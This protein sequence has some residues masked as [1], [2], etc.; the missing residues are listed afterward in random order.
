[1]KHTIFRL[2]FS[3]ALLIFLGVPSVRAF[4]SDVLLAGVMTERVVVK[5]EPEQSYAVYLPANYT[6]QR[7]WPTIICFDPGA[8][9]KFAVEHL[10]SAAEKF[11]YVVACSNNSRNALDGE[12]V[13]KIVSALW[14]DTHERIAIND[15]RTYLAGFSG[16]A[17]LAVGLAM[18]CNGCVA[19]VIASGA[20]LPG[21]NQPSAQL[22]FFFFGV[23]GYDDFNFGEMRELE[24]KFDELAT[25]HR[26]YRFAGGHEW[27]PQSAIEKA[28]A[29]FSLEAMKRQVL[30]KDETFIDERF[31]AELNE[32][33]KLRAEQ[34][35]IDSLSAYSYIAQSFGSLRDT[36]LVARKAEELRNSSE[37]KKQLQ[38]ESDLIRRQAQETSDI[39]ALWMKPPQPDE[40][41]TSRAEARNKISEWRKKK[42]AEIDS[43]DRRLARRVL[44]SLRIG[45][46]EDAA[47][48]MR[49]KNYLTA[50]ADLELVR[51]VEPQ[52]SNPAY[53]LARAQ[54]LNKDKK[55]ALQTLTEAVEL[56]FKDFERLKTDPAFAALAADTRFQ[57]LLSDNR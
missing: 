10:K 50:I 44:T 15:Q 18:R 38:L 49:T 8:R 21:I 2:V 16:G 12:T 14:R 25:P 41:L 24:K 54:A 48:A 23:V 46:F 57:K 20:G 6:S 47:G 11:G 35:L 34:Q 3:V 31:R 36:T 40:M 55:A 19:G 9:G 52:A 29:S 5:A 7:Q 26:F 17:R 51:A 53:E 1:M 42:D 30:A 27:P 37:L 22:P 13:G 45:S 39:R 28:L 56:G 43:R 33:D 32:A 4:Q